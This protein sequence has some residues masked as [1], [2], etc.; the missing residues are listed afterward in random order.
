MND[1]IYAVTRVH[2]QEQNMLDRGDLERLIAAKTVREA[3]RLLK[4]KGWGSQDLKE[5]DPDALIAYEQA[6]TWALAE[7]LIKDLKPFSLFRLNADYQ[8]LKAAIKFQSARHAAGDAQRYMLPGGTIPPEA[9]TKAATERDF[10]ALPPEMAEVAAR[11]NEALLRSGNGQLADLILDAGALTAIDLA[12]KASPSALMR[13]YARIVVDGAIARIAF[14]AARM[15]LQ[16]DALEMAIPVAGSLDRKAIIAAALTGPEAVLQA[17]ESTEY[18]GAAAEGQ[19]SAA[20]LERWFDDY[21]MEKL[22]PQRRVYEG[23]DPIAAFLIGREREIDAVRL[24][25][26]ALQNN[27]SG[28]RVQERLRALY[29]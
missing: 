8:N 18:A 1:T 22:R 23:Y 25:L 16:R 14:R 28:D 9:L 12:G 4:D 20:A 13:Q 26:A 17:L 5:D 21:L 19:K 11:A 27:I 10:S 24:I 15:G 3:L 2:Y 29:V 6:R 7:E